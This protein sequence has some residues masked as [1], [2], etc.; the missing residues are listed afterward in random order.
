MGGREDYEER[1]EARKVKYERLAKKAEEKSEQYSNST[2][3]KILQM[4]PGQPIIIG[5]HSENKARKLHERAWKDIEKSIRKDEKSKYYKNKVESIENSKVI[6]SDDPNAISKLKQKLEK[7]EKEKAIMK[8]QGY[9]KWAITNIGATI[10]ETK[11]RIERL[12]RQE[13]IDFHDIEFKNG[14]AIHNK[15]INRIQL[16]FE[17]IPS[18]EIRKELKSNGFHWSRYEGAW[19][20]AFN[21]KTI[22]V[23][24]WLINNVIEKEDVKQEQEEEEFE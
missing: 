7:L 20:R 23:T 8:E 1:K 11:K 24:E 5:H 4:T 6:Y 2:A 19:Q 3:N 17:E 12:E 18:E 16:I 9:E 10:R 13:N 22:K 21:E 14:K 15:N